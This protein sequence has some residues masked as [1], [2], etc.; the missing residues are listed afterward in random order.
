MENYTK[1]IKSGAFVLIALIVVFGT[2]GTVKAGERGV[3]TRFGS[4]VGIV[5][6][7][8]YLK[9]PLIE[10][11]NKISVKT[12]TVTYDKS[13]GVLEG[14]SKDLQDVSISVVVNYHIEP[15]HVGEIFS[16]Y[17]SSQVFE[18]K[19]V[20]PIIREI[21][22]SLS[23]QYTAE[24]LITKRVEYSDRVN[25]ALSEALM[26][27]FAVLERFSVTNFQLSQSFTAAIEAKVTAVQNAEGA[28]NKLE[29]VKFEAQQQIEKAKA[30][31][32]SIRIQ[33][34]AITQ[35]GGREYVNLQA[36]NKW[37]G[38]LPTQM[39]P[40]GALPFINLDK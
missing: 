4:V 3:K 18:Q 15:L 33:A 2:F 30:E 24:E 17:R 39:I 1:Y 19:V 22:K 7:G 6:E 35:Q 29:Q 40:S 27:K 9:V 26:N 36:V 25:K 14:A 37:D 11:V 10:K 12:E 5:D 23:A 21:T 31:A 8:L 32:E 20:E 28:K 38:K 16:Q 13:T 34:Q